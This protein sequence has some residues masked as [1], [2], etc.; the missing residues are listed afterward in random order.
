MRAQFQIKFL[1]YHYHYSLCF[2]SCVTAAV[3]LSVKC[4]VIHLPLSTLLGTLLSWKYSW[5]S[6]KCSLKQKLLINHQFNFP[7]SV[8]HL[9]SRKI[10]KTFGYWLLYLFSEMCMK[11]FQWF[12][13]FWFGNNLQHMTFLMKNLSIYP[14]LGPALHY[15]RVMAVSFHLT[16][17][18]F[19]WSDVEKWFKHLLFSNCSHRSLQFTISIAP[20]YYRNRGIEKEMY[21]SHNSFY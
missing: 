8:T 7:C 12:C 13:T 20:K 11:K 6:R 5:K 9:P 10:N 18:A 3:L 2:S 16:N 19:S 4:F 14:G 1:V 17:S 15:S 21:F